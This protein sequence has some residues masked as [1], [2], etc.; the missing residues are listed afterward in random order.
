[1][2]QGFISRD[3]FRNP[4]EIGTRYFNELHCRSFFEH[5]SLDNNK[6]ACVFAAP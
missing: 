6:E 2:S 4:E 3:K 1:M 5:S